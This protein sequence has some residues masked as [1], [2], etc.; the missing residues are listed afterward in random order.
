MA[1]RPASQAAAN[2]PREPLDWFLRLLHHLGWPA[3]LAERVRPL[4]TGRS[5][6]SDRWAGA[7][8][9]ALALH[10]GGP[11]LLVEAPFA[12][13]PVSRCFERFEDLTDDLRALAATMAREG[14]DAPTVVI[15]EPRGSAQVIDF[16]QEEALLATE[17]RDETAERV[18]PLLDPGAL[19]RGSLASHPRKSAS[20]RALELARW[21][22]IWSGRLGGAMDLGHEPVAR[23]FQWLHLAR[24]AERFGLAGPRH[25]PFA[26]HRTHRPG[27]ALRNLTGLW[28]L[29]A[30][31][32]QFLQG[33]RRETMQRL[34][35]AIPPAL[36]DECLA[37]FARLSVTKFSAP[38]LFE[39]FADDEWRQQSWRA[40]VVPDALPRFADDPARLLVEP[41]HVALDEAGY[42]LLLAGFDAMVEALLRHAG[43][44]ATAASRGESPGVQLDVFGSEPP[45]TLAEEDVALFVLGSCIRARTAL[46]SR[47]ELTRM[48]LLALAA[49]WNARLR[50]APAHYPLVPVRVE[51]PRATLLA[52]SRRLVMPPADAS[53]N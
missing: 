49:Q 28:R 5:P 50:P 25:V 29:L 43:E 53:N 7:R 22:G 15:L 13:E 47:G 30:D 20:R 40:A 14:I 32:R 51:A 19:I 36:L 34:A 27:A 10:E 3:S 39:A 44:T 42:A 1:R 35:E 23:F 6:A 37:S 46:R 33:E 48:G 12:L 11:L 38:I 21:T 26:R 52:S 8:H 18:A 2:T 45:A 24:V 4:A 16:V 31:E 17:S 41:W 9:T